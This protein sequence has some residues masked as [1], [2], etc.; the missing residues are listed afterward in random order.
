MEGRLLRSILTGLMVTALAVPA[1]AND[2]TFGGGASDLVPLT[3]HRVRMLSEEILIEYRERWHITA[4]Y[5]FENHTKRTVKAVVGFPEYRCLDEYQDC[6]D[7]PFQNLKT[8][9]AGRLVSHRKGQLDSSHDW[10]PYLGDVWL[11]DATFPKEKITTIVHRYSVASG[12]DVSENRSIVYVTRTGAKWSGPIGRARFTYRLPATA[13]TVNA[14]EGIQLVSMRTVEP[15]GP[16]PYVEL[17][18]EQDNWTPQGDLWL[19]FN[20]STSMAV[21][22]LGDEALRRS[23]LEKDD[24]CPPWSERDEATPGQKQMCIN[25]GYAVRGYPFK[26][27]NL[28][29]YYYGGTKEWRSE[30]TPWS[31]TETWFVRGLRAFPG[32]PEWRSG[33]PGASSDNGEGEAPRVPPLKTEAPLS[34]KE[35]SRGASSPKST[36]SP[37]TVHRSARG[38]A[39]HQGPAERAYWPMLVLFLTIAFRRRS[40]LAH[41]GNA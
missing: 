4:R 20:E 18:L 39:L 19:S 3:E 30:A 27:K 16:S 25:D 7:S 34:A 11:F 22:R 12:S 28:Q 36:N 33:K 40:S 24:I 1:S 2:A 5:Q 21:D 38:C 37:P 10:E 13:H 8:E 17:V 15:D 31:S 23:G 32:L 26:R 9:V 41:A 6:F 14:P 29:A 35:P